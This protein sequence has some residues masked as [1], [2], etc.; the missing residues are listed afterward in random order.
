MSKATKPGLWPILFIG[1]MVAACH[2]APEARVP[3]ASHLGHFGFGPFRTWDE[4][5]LQNGGNKN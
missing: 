1:R 5:I 3:R 4:G 2:A